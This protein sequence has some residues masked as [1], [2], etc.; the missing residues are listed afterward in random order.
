MSKEMTKMLFAIDILSES[1]SYE[2]KEKRISEASEVV[3]R[4]V[5]ESGSQAVFDDWTNYL[6][7]SVHTQKEAW[8]FMILF[9]NFE[10]HMFKVNNPYPFLGLLYKKLD[11]SFDKLP[12]DDDEIQMNDTFDSI[13]I[14][15]LVGSGII[16]LEDYFYVNPYNDA[17]LIDAY[18][19]A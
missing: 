13:Y 2:E 15:L 4:L 18:N 16:K 14:E 19:Q 12:T 3:K 8:N 1:M 9:F 10:G 11:L 6:K 17:K 5:D 7:E